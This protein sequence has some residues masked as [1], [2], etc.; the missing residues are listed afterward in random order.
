MRMGHTQQNGFLTRPPARLFA[1]N[2]IPMVFIMMM[3]GLLNVV[4]AI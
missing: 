3:N 2:A 4:D 1:E